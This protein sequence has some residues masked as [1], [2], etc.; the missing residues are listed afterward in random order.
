MRSLFR[1]TRKS[2]YKKILNTEHKFATLYV[3]NLAQNIFIHYSVQYFNLKKVNLL[4]LL[5]LPDP[6]KI[7]DS[8]RISGTS[9]VPTLFVQELHTAHTEDATF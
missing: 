6:A 5:I 3:I 4:G 7:P 2:K 9:L 8:E 1:R